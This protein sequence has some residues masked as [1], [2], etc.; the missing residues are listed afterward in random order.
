MLVRARTLGFLGPGPVTRHVAHALGFSRAIGGARGSS[1]LFAPGTATSGCC[2]ER[3]ARD[4]LRLA[5]LGSGGGVPGLVLAVTEPT[6]RVALVDANARRCEFLAEAI[7]QVGW[8][9]RVAVVHDRAE[10]VGR[11]AEHRGSYDVVTARSFG[12]PAVTAECAAP[13]LLTGGLL[14]TS[15][16]PIATGPGGSPVEPAPPAGAGG[17]DQVGGRTGVASASGRW[18]VAGLEQ[19]GM[20]PLA[21]QVDVFAYQVV[22]QVTACPHRYPR[23]VGMPAKRPLF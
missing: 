19:L 6:W 22:R 4:G 23:R 15:E 21:P 13:L 9:S 3:G 16:P 7:R 11:D 17:V 1:V 14:V 10:T 8:T 18:P 12:P 20:A 5:D 2:P